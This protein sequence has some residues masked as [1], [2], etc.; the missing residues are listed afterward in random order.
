MRGG[1]GFLRRRGAGRDFSTDGIGWHSV[2]WRRSVGHGFPP[3]KPAGTME[4][5]GTAFARGRHPDAR[6][7]ICAGATA[8]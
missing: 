5:D 8:E 4:G 2:A 1:S 3:G 7:R 6:R